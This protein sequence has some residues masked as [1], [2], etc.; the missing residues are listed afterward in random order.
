MI[1][2]MLARLFDGYIGAQFPL[3]ASTPGQTECCVAVVEKQR[4]ERAE[5]TLAQ[6]RASLATYIT[7]TAGPVAATT[8]ALGLIETYDRQEATR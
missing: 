8:D 5:A 7:G 4:R 3:L 2:R 6:V 1:R